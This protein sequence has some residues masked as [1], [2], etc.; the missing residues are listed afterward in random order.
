MRIKMKR[1]LGI[2]LSLALVL[3][4]MP[5]MSMTVWAAEEHVTLSDGC[6]SS[7]VISSSGF[8]SSFGDLAVI[9]KN[10]SATIKANSGVII[11]KVIIHKG[12]IAYKSNFTSA[13][14]NVSP[15]TLSFTSDTCTVTNI[16]SSSVKLSKKNNNKNWACSSVEV[17]YTVP[18][19]NVTS[20]TLDSSKTVRVGDNVELKATIAPANATDKTVK[21]SVGGTNADAVKLYSDKACTS[22]VGTGATDT[23][24]V[25]AKGV[26]AGNA[27]VTCISNADNTKTASCTVNVHSHNFTYEGD[28]SNAATI[29]ATCSEDGC[30]LTDNKA[31]L[32]IKGDGING[33]KIIGDTDAFD[34]VPTI[35]YYKVEQDAPGHGNS[36]VSDVS[37]EAGWYWAEFTRGDKTAHVVYEV[38]AIAEI[39]TKKYSSI[40]AAITAATDNDTI[41]LLADTKERITFGKSGTTVTL[42]LNGKK[43]DGDQQGTVITINNGTLVLDDSSNDSEISNKPGVI[44]GGK[45]TGNGGGV[46]VNGGIFTLKDGRIE[47]NTAGG[48][49]AGVYVDT[50]GTFNMQGGIIQG[51]V[52]NNG[53]GVAVAKSDTIRFTMSGGSIQYN[54][55]YGNT[56]GVLLNGGTPFA[57][58]GGKIQYNVGKNFGGI[59]SANANIQVSGTAYIKDNYTI[60]DIS[61]TTIKVEAVKDSSDIITGY[62]LVDGVETSGVRNDVCQY[63]TGTIDVVGALTDGARIGV[64]SKYSNVYN[65]TNGAAFT[66]GYAYYNPNDKASKHFFSDDSTYGIHKVGE[67]SSTP[68]VGTG[69]LCFGAYYP[70]HEHE[71]ENY[72]ASGADITA[73]CKNT[74]NGCDLREN[75]QAK[76]VTLLTIS[77]TGGTYDGVTSFGAAITDHQSVLG[78]TTPEIN[79]YKASGSGPDYTR[80]DALATPTAAPKDA[81][82]IWAEFTYEGQTAHVV[83][84]IAPKAL[85][86]KWSDTVFTYDGTAHKPTAT[87][88]GIIGEA[89]GDNTVTIKESKAWEKIN[90]GTYAPVAEIDTN[91]SGNY[92]LGASATGSFTIEKKAVTVTANNQNIGIGE[93]I[94]GEIGNATL[95][96]ALAGHTLSEVTLS[97]K[98]GTETTHANAAGKIEATGAKIK[99]ESNNDMT[100]N[101]AITY[102][103]GNLCVVGKVSYVKQNSDG[104]WAKTFTEVLTGEGDNTDTRPGTGT[105]FVMDEA[106]VNKYSSDYYHLAGYAKTYT[107]TGGD[108][109]NY[110]TMTYTSTYSG[111]TVQLEAT[112]DVLYLF[113]ERDPKGVNIHR[114]SDDTETYLE[115]DVPYG[116]T[117]ADTYTKIKSS[118]DDLETKMEAWWPDYTFVGWTTTKGVVLDHLYSSANTPATTDK[119][120]NAIAYFKLKDE[121]GTRNSTETVGTDGLKLYPLLI[122][123]KVEVHLDLGAKDSEYEKYSGSSG[124]WYTT[125]QAAYGN[126]GYDNDTKATMS[127]QDRKFVVVLGDKVKETAP[128]PTRFGYDY[129][130]WCTS[131]GLQWDWTANTAIDYMDGS[132]VYNATEGCSYYTLTLSAHWKLKK[133]KVEYA[134]PDS[135]G[136]GAAINFTPTIDSGTSEAGYALNSEIS[137]H[138]NDVTAPTENVFV[139]WE[140]TDRNVYSSI[141]YRNE[142]LITTYGSDLNTIKL[143]A[144]FRPAGNVKFDSQGGTLITVATVEANKPFDLQTSVGSNTYKNEYIPERTGYK[145]D[146]WYT[147]NE[148]QAVYVTGNVPEGTGNPIILYAHWT[149]NQYTINFDAEGG[150]AV[151]PLTLDYDAAIQAEY[152]AT[153][154]RE[155]YTFMGWAPALPDKMPAIGTEGLTVHAIWKVNQ[156]DLTYNTN[157][158]SNSDSF[159]QT[160]IDYGQAVAEPATKP[161]KE[162]FVFQCWGI[163]TDT[164]GTYTRVNFP[165][166]MPTKAVA[167]TALWKVNQ[168]APEAPVVPENGVQSRSVKVTAVQG[169]EYIILE[170][171]SDITPE[172]IKNNL[173]ESDWK[174]AKKPAGSAETVEWTGLTPNKDYIVFARVSA[175]G[176]G[177]VL[178]ETTLTVTGE[179]GEIGKLASPSSVGVS[180]KTPKE[181]QNA[182]AKPVVSTYTQTTVTLSP[183]DANQ[184]YL[185]LPSNAD[186]TEGEYSSWQAPEE[187]ATKVVFEKANGTDTLTPGTAYKIYGRLKATYTQNA[188]PASSA[189]EVTTLKCANSFTKYAKQTVALTY[190]GLQQAVIPDTT[191]AKPTSTGG[192][193]E[194]VLTADTVTTAPAEGWSS[195]IPEVINAGSYYLWYRVNGD[196]G[197]KPYYDHVAPVRIQIVIE[198]KEVAFTWTYTVLTYNGADQAPEATITDGLVGNDAGRKI[199]VEGGQTNAGEGYI[200]TAAKVMKPKESTEGEF[201]EDTNYKLPGANTTTFKIN[202]RPI[203]ITANEQSVPRYESIANGTEYVTISESGLADGD[204]LN[205]ISLTAS[206]TANVTTEGNKEKITPSNA[207]IK[208]GGTDVTSNYSINYMEGNLTVTKIKAVKNAGTPAA[209]E[210]EYGKTIKDSTIDGS[211]VT[212]IEQFTGDTVEGTWSWK[213]E[214][215]LSPNV[216]GGNCTALFTPTDTT[217]FDPTEVEV[218]VP[219]VPSE[220]S[221][222]TAPQAI[223]PTYNNQEQE[224][225]RAG[226]TSD[227]T[228]YYAL[229]EGNNAECP[230]FTTGEGGNWSTSVPKAKEIGTYLVWYMIEGDSN[231]FDMD[232]EPLTVRINRN[233]SHY[234]TSEVTKEPTCTETGIETFTCI[235][236]ATYEE[237]IPV[238]EHTLEAHEAKEATCAEYGNKEYWECTECKKLFTDKDGKKET[239]EDKIKVEK[240]PHTLTAHEAEEATCT[241]DGKKAYWECS[242]CKK[243]FSDAEGKTETTEEALVEKAKGHKLTAHAEVKATCDKEGKKAYWE[244][245]ECDKLFADAEGKTEITEADLVIEK[246]AHKLTRVEAVEATPDKDG[247]IEYWTCSDCEKCFADPEGKT[248]ITMDQ[249]ILPMSEHKLSLVPEKKATCTED[250]NKAYYTCS[251]CDKLFED[252]AGKKEIALKDTVIKAEGHKLTHV[253]AVEPTADKEGSIEYWVC[254]ECGKL[255]SDA[256]GKNEISKEDTVIAKY[257]DITKATVTGLATKAYTGKAITPVVTL[258]YDGKTL[259]KGTDYTVTY[260]NNTNVGTATV[261]IKGKGEYAGTIT[262]KFLIKQISFKYRAYVQKKNWMSW[263]VAKVSGTEASK[264][265]GTTQNLRM[266]TIQM[267]LTGVSGAVEYR[268]Y[269]ANKGW[270]QWATTADKSTYAGTKGES[271]RVELIQLRA[272][273]QVATLYDMY[274]RAY[275]E[276]F[277]WLNWAKNGEKAGTQGYAYKLEAFQVNFVRK[278]ETFK[279]VSQNKKA[280]SFYDKTR[281]GANPK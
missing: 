250:G 246:E 163:A 256:E 11:T 212:M 199:A 269:C 140:G 63:G 279:L 168:A 69:E 80:G 78:D 144:A 38:P 60:T 99:D 202:K 62:K 152:S 137:L 148:N 51:N 222:T 204:S 125:S 128:E 94:A 278:G 235:C 107:G 280:K 36:T 84:T 240:K 238:K 100:N 49:G 275:S 42:D 193:V 33:A 106:I 3:G 83:Y 217:N 39:G 130:R 271:R 27:T 37:T 274:F 191:E 229:T 231:H 252:P 77:A 95:T 108:T 43:I 90:A 81:G 32:T 22:E 209:T 56:G 98:S 245:S 265:A 20:L 40:A 117:Y 74:D 29:I 35:T 147:D 242:V 261:T 23:L 79:Y 164:E 13:Y 159:A 201:E 258:K 270:T 207:V 214:N 71:W 211:G 176:A 75:D 34:E 67:E 101:Y 249:I 155:G 192:T 174:D 82:T 1:F 151:A 121:Q 233:H 133:A 190:N 179:N 157:G 61:A 85:T 68:G 102:V 66:T 109:D 169:N 161:T 186:V 254:S 44:T 188:S 131:D 89:T 183:I 12:N 119:N 216:P 124:E 248:E 197:G 58:S 24:T 181:D 97:T 172:Q 126:T 175:T 194:Y 113:Y 8:S 10:G 103:D 259:K 115:I 268:A 118:L 170:K 45:T 215:Q 277:G 50:N 123:D 92:T 31:T 73:T 273:G 46:V 223:N 120:S 272:K 110:A 177:D 28:S 132:K 141:V 53:G 165:F 189:T 226:V 224:L 88:E 184:E 143:T 5:G 266:E 114:G 127:G 160:S 182:P 166:N 196:V 21:W 93:N 255:F 87:V 244:C 230:E 26:L 72:A 16:N 136:N 262:K 9:G 167:L 149:I 263:S 180:V 156:Y 281:D 111:E 14:V 76:I 219:V 247:N 135:P 221:F 237:E 267:Q 150:S 232:F 198:P 203:D 243:L 65:Y 162:G 153:S 25:Y 17:Y 64:A 134:L 104:T 57:M 105:A 41:K 4:L 129:E 234:Y 86:V 228:I 253:E 154:S 206:S 218:Y 19:I 59:G 205:S 47:G 52:A 15:G 54:E 210:L 264:M 251:H 139:G 55:G 178:A 70:L 187:N 213:V 185:L 145:F 96:G 173:K 260:A 6:L 227:G 112:D 208:D 171:V 30:T 91:P 239:T 18:S 257:I 220:A 146:Y 7:G 2:L 138:N 48:S 276:K 200:A 142:D 236:G 225:I 122:K 116:C 158:A 241:E 195:D